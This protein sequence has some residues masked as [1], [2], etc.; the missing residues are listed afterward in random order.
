MIINN[1]SLFN[2]EVRRK[3][4]TNMKKQ[5][6]LLE[7]Q[8]LITKTPA[9]KVSAPKGVMMSYTNLYSEARQRYSELLSIK[10]SKEAA[11]EKAPPG[12][13]HV[14]KT[15]HGVQYY[16]RNESTD[17]S[18]KYIHKSEK[19]L[20]KKYLQKS[21]DEKILR[22]VTM[23][24]E[25][26][27]KLLF[28]TENVIT[29]V[30]NVYSDSPAEVKELIIPIDVSDEDYAQKWLNIP[31]EGKVIPDLLPFFE[32]KRKERVRS[33]SELNIANALA[34]KGIPYKYECPLQLSN[35]AIIYP[36]FTVLDV[37]RRRVMYWEH[38]G[39]MD[40]KDYAKNSVQRIK[41]LMK[42]G[43]FIGEDL[44]ITEETSTNPLGTN[45][46]E[47]VIKRFLL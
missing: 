39:M 31:Y 35:G 13:I 12:K 8:A 26:L 1:K 11:L 42:E 37:K 21:Y 47:A 41:T 24:S 9:T 22:L 25:S 10:N 16:L 7:N 40:D 4:I 32:T 38:R 29:A 15:S 44:I 5:N 46:I 18:G 14:S 3:A 28:K 27:K 33:K 2:R 23:E 36:D 20:I 43:L 19:S 17:K 34:D 6:N 45:E 30:Q